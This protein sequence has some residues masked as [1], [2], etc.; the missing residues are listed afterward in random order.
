MFGAD[1]STGPHGGDVAVALCGERDLAGPE[2]ADSRGAPAT[3]GSPRRI[4]P[5]GHF[6]WPRG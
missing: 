1:L 6:R 2:F 5:P 4:P 3:A